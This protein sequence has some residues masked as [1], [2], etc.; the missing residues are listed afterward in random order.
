MRLSSVANRLRAQVALEPNKARHLANYAVATSLDGRPREARRAMG[1]AICLKVDASKSYRGL[2]KLQTAFGEARDALANLRRAQ[3]LNPDDPD[4]LEVDGFQKFMIGDH[5]DAARVLRHVNV[6]VPTRWT[7]WVARSEALAAAGRPRE[8]LTAI[9]RAIDLEFDA[10]NLYL[11]LS[12]LQIEL[13]DRPAARVN[14]R[15]SL[16]LFPASPNALLAEG[17]QAT[18]LGDLEEARRALDH[19]T[20]VAPER[21]PAWMALAETLAS[22]GRTRAARAC[23]ETMIDTASVSAK[24]HSAAIFRMDHFESWSAREAQAERR[25]W[26]RRH[27]ARYF[28]EARV[29]RNDTGPDRKLRVGY[30]SAD[31]RRHSAME[32]FGPIITNHDKNIVG[33]FIYSNS[34]VSDVRTKELKEHVEAWRD[35][36]DVSD[37]DL[38]LM[39]EN[40]TVDIL[41]DL[42]GHSLGNR[43]PAFARKPAPVQVTAWG[44]AL[45]TGLRTMDYFFTDPVMT[46]PTEAG[47]YAE[48]CVYLPCVTPFRIPDTPPPVEDMP[49]SRNQ[50]ITF[51]CFNRGIKVSLSA[52]R[53]WCRILGAVKNSRLLLKSAEF[54]IEGKRRTVR[55][56]MREMDID[57]ERVSFEGRTIRHEHLAAHG[58]IDIA[59]DTFPQNGGVTTWEALFMGVPVIT[60]MGTGVAQRVSGAILKVMDA[61]EFIA[62]T[63]ADYVEISV[64]LGNDIDRLRAL[65]KSLRRRVIDCDATN[66]KVYTRHVDTA[67]RRMWRQW[68][69]EQ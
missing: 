23:L 66:Y 47:E 67:Y 44:H 20:I 31:F 63:E 5:A 18:A 65:R 11:S 22:L 24:I 10:P 41:V 33:T 68:C 61:D 9:S 64:R 8:A 54:E 6:M 48:S 57:P 13:K 42:S 12:K 27:G 7:A 16:C 14:L 21:W 15:R 60:W 46:P 62:E 43:L 30:V 1:R 49:E 50:F 28:R 39:I 35:V 4:T 26:W 19:A 51:G 32:I 29:F 58:R 3:C 40:D 52:I 55:E 25:N 56:N 69:S 37:E 59:L 53:A 2:A 45:G 34:H 17:L 36:A 38:A